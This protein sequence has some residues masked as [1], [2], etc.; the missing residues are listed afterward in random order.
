MLK[1]IT[2]S[3]TFWHNTHSPN[4]LDQCLSW[5][6]WSQRPYLWKIWPGCIQT[7]KAY[8]THETAKENASKTNKFIAKSNILRWNISPLKPD[9]TAWVVDI[10]VRINSICYG[11]FNP[12]HDGCVVRVAVYQYNRIAC[13]TCKRIDV[14]L[15]IYKRLNAVIP[16]EWENHSGKRYCRLSGRKIA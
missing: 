4:G 15:P 12:N 1:A 6:C 16:R 9:M 14:E 11:Q 5:C 2:S 10:R 8:D 7:S 3:Q 13:D